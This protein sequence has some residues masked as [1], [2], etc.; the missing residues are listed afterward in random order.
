MRTRLMAFLMI[1]PIHSKPFNEGEKDAITTTP[2][3]DNNLHAKDKKPNQTQKTHIPCP[4]P[5]HPKQ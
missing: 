3:N 4:D 1:N 5:R 2:Q